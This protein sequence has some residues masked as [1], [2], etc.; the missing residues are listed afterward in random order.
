[1]N[2]QAGTILPRTVCPA[3]NGEA[4]AIIS[5]IEVLKSQINAGAQECK[6]L[7]K[8][9][10]NISDVINDPQWQNISALFRTNQ[11]PALEAADVDAMSTLV[12]T[13]SSNLTEVI[14]GGSDCIK[15]SERGSF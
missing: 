8:K 2:V 3:I 7:N 1:M 10:A 14:A 12:Q 5:K 9:L 4:Q 11:V 13:A 15:K 6:D